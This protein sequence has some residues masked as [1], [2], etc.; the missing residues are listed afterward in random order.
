VNG[1]RDVLPE[2]VQRPGDLLGCGDHDQRLG[3]DEIESGKKS[4]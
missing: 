2:V 4:P 3:G 1:G